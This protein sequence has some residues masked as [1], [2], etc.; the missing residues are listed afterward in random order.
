MGAAGIV[1]EYWEEPGILL[2]VE[3][4]VEARVWSTGAEV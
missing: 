2:N 4:L 3:V 1:A